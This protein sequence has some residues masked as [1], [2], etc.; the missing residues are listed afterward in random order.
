LLRKWNFFHREPNWDGEFPNDFV[1]ADLTVLDRTTGLMWTRQVFTDCSDFTGARLLVKSFNKKRYAGCLDWRLPT[2]EEAASL[3]CFERRNTDRNYISPA[4]FISS[5]AYYM[6]TADA[7]DPGEHPPR[8]L[9]AVSFL[10]GEFC[11]VFAQKHAWFG[12]VH[13]RLCRSHTSPRGGFPVWHSP[14]PEPEP[15]IARPEPPGPAS[16]PAPRRPGPATPGGKSV[17]AAAADF[18]QIRILPGR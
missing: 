11:P 7:A 3:L 12:T 18:P 13:L 1:A 6:L 10:L 8:L 17:P 4:F 2:L 5:S 15:R 9:W 14:R 16:P